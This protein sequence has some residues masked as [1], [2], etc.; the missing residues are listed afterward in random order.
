MESRQARDPLVPGCKVW[1]D[2]QLAI[3]IGVDTN[4]PYSTEFQALLQPLQ[5]AAENTY[6]YFAKITCL[7][8]ASTG[9]EWWFCQ[10]LATAWPC[11]STSSA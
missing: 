11:T 8:A 1:V 10:V 6:E 2:P 3:I 9:A 5:P 4:W 7:R